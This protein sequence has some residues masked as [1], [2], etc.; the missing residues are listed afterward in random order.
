MGVMVWVTLAAAL[1]LLVVGAEVLVRG[2][3]RLAVAMGISPLV[4][5]LTVVAY[6]TSSP[7]MAVSVQSALAGQA[8]IALG[9]VIGSN[10]FNVL[11]ILGLSALITPLVV[12]LQLVRRDVPIMI[13]VSLLLWLMALNGGVERWE[14]G[15]LFGGVVAYTVWSVWQSRRESKQVV[16]EEFGEA[17]PER[18]ALPLLKNLA[19]IG[20]GLGLLVLGS[21]WLVSSAVSL[22]EAWGVSQLVIGLT[23]VAAGTSLPEVA[24][25]VVASLRGERDI[26][27]G[28]VVG[29]NIF[30]I[31]SVLGLAA[32]VSPNGVAVSSAAL[33]FDMPV[34]VLVALACLPIFFTG[35]VIAR[36]EGGLFLAFYVGYTLYLVLAANG[37]AWLP[38]VGW[39]LLAAATLAALVLAASVA[40]ALRQ[41]RPGLER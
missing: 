34:M 7:E 4:V 11:F 39:A 35:G 22:A 8:D 3:S 10:I 32:V 25:S 2:A 28:N 17:Q 30:N 33:A 15:L 6:G 13:G 19:F 24:T 41:H 9:N 20:A 12:S 31:L 26:A 21:N 29:S 1:A 37:S 16:A 38:G 36:W 14:G 5:G 27:V 40:Q 18:G 23:I